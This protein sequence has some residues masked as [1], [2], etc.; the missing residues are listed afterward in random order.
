MTAFNLDAYLARIG[1]Q[2]PLE[3]TIETLAALTRAHMTRIPFENLDVLLGRGIRID[4]ESVHAKLVAAG[5]GGYCYEHATLLQAA[6]EAVGF[7]PAAHAALVLM[8]SR[9]ET[10][11]THMFLSLHI[12]DA[13]VVVDPGFGGHGP[14]VPVP[15]AEGLDAS[16]GADL[17]RLVRRGDE[18]VLEARI[19]GTMTALWISTLEPRQPEDFLAGNQYVSSSP[20]SPFV[21]R[22]MLRAVTPRGRTSVLNRTVTVRSAG[23]AET[24]ELADRAALRA[25]LA[26]DFGFDMPEAEALRVP[27][28]PEWT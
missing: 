19:D 18:W 12:G 17:H 20:A 4:V 24:R 3:P 6:L 2:G 13:H 23:R 8:P 9:P 11:R 25:L 1:W 16:D 5:R 22:L 10:L 7:R 28:V 21:N 15:L 14:I 26:A 27:A